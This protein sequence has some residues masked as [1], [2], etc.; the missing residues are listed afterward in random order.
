M[1]IDERRIKVEYYSNELNDLLDELS[2]LTIK[3]RP[4]PLRKKPAESLEL[5]KEEADYLLG[6]KD[7]RNGKGRRLTD[8]Q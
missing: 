4:L 2:T 6:R 7:R 8:Y 3:F 5:I 1:T